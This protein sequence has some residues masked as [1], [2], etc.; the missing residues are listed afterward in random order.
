MPRRR[1]KQLAPEHAYDESNRR[2]TNDD[3]TKNTMLKSSN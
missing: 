1:R 2:K 3:N